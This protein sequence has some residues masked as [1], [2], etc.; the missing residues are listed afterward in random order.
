LIFLEDATFVLKEAETSKADIE[1]ALQEQ[2]GHG[3][4]LLE[5]GEAA[6]YL[7]SVVRLRPETRKQMQWALTVGVQ[8]FQDLREMVADWTSREGVSPEGAQD[9]GP[10][11]A[12]MDRY[13]AELA[14]SSQGRPRDTGP[15]H[16]AFPQVGTPEWGRMNQRRAEL[17]RKSLRGELSEGERQEYETLQRLSLAAVEAT[18]PRQD[19]NGGN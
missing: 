1:G 16:R 15:D 13:R 2:I 17:I 6:C 11:V 5:M 19:D 12:E 4:Q 18:F 8:A 3:K 14:L 9:L 7:A 10:L